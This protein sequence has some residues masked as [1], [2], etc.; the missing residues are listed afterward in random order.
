MRAYAERLPSQ[1]KAP[2][3]AVRWTGR[4][5]TSRA[6]SLPTAVIIGAQKSGTTSLYSYLAAHP[7]V[8]TPSK[9]EVHYFDL[10]WDRGIDWYRAHFP[11]VAHLERLRRAVGDACA[12]VRGEPLLPGAP[13]RPAAAA[14]DA[15]RGEAHRRAPRAGRARELPLPP[16]VQERGGSRSISLRRPSAS[17]S[18]SETITS[19]CGPAP[20]VQSAAHQH[21]GYLARGRYAEQLEAWF[22]VF[23]SEQLLVLDSRAL[24]DRP[25]ETMERTFEFLGLPPSRRRLIRAGRRRP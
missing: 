15:A 9:K 17:T 23:A 5:A 21:L 25:A 20:L 6:R 14:R 1:V 11:T 3:R 18:G 19:A 4:R 16:R 12:D 13:T 7:A 22:A 8:A 24:F 10:N 2:V